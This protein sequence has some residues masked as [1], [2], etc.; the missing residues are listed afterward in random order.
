MT[1]SLSTIGELMKED[2]VMGSEI[3]L[4]DKIP[5]YN[6]RSD[7]KRWKI[8]SGYIRICIRDK[9]NEEQHR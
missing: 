9:R 4:S 3:V 8:L 1:R 6:R 7:G 5:T 2:E